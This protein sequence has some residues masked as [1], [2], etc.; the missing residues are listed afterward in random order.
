MNL[1]VVLCT[2]NR[3][4]LL[5]R[6]LQSLEAVAVPAG[7]AWELLVVDNN[8]TDG[9]RA[10][11]EAAAARRVLPCRYVFEP[12]QG[13]SHALNTG[14]AET[15]GDVIAFTD[16]DVTFDSGWLA[17]LWR[18]FD[19]PDCLGLGGRIV[20]VWSQPK[21]SWYAEQGPYRLMMAIVRYE[22][23]EQPIPAPQPPYGANM[24]YRRA[25]FQRY[26][27]FDPSLGPSARTLMRGEDTEFGRRV[28]AAGGRV[29]YQPDA[30]VYHPVEPARLRRGYFRAF[31]YHYGRMEVRT[32]APDG[33]AVHWFGVPRHLFRSLAAHGGRSVIALDPQRRFYH[34]L[35]SARVAGQIVESYRRAHGAAS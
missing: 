7:L 13:K 21:P 8:S 20:A 24:A 34:Q 2:Y 26:G 1:S 14:L 30:I 4:A 9:T 32:E 6:A 22:Y 16:D 3:A 29:R 18:G 19:D 23:G 10:V 25:A 5:S 35:E 31:Y 27:G 12:R 33:S 28:L 17:A 15:T 11:V